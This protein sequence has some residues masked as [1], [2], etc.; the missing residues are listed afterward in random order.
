[1]TSRMV[2][3]AGGAKWFS[4]GV[5]AE[6]ASSSTQLRHLVRRGK[7]LGLRVVLQTMNDSSISRCCGAMHDLSHEPDCVLILP[8]LLPTPY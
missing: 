6:L 5:G 3:P 1:M 2:A 4:N 8:F 7:S